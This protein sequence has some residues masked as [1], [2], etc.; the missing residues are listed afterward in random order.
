MEWRQHKG[1]LDLE[2]ERIDRAVNSGK[3]VELREPKGVEEN[4]WIQE[5]LM[6]GWAGTRRSGGDPVGEFNPYREKWCS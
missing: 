6:R 1:W 4:P 3:E 5:L 2:K